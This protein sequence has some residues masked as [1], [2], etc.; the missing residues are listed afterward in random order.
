MMLTTATVSADPKRATIR[1]DP[2]WEDDDPVL[3]E[4][5]IAELEIYVTEHAVTQ[6]KLFLVKTQ[7]CYNGLIQD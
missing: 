5:G 1:I 7:H 4:N 6:A 2:N 3:L